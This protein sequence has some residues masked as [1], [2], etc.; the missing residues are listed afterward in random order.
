MKRV[1]LLSS[2]LLIY[3]TSYAQYYSGE[4]GF[5]YLNIPISPSSQSFSTAGAAALERD[6]DMIN[7]ASLLLCKDDK[8][9]INY[10]NYIAGSHF[11]LFTYN[12]GGS[13]IFLKYFNSGLIERRD[14]LNTDLGTYSANAVMA[15]YSK[16]FRISDKMTL[17][18]GINL[19]FENITDYKGLAASFDLGFIFRNIYSDFL[20]AGVNVT[21]LGALYDFTETSLSPAKVVAGVSIS[22]ED[23][24]FAVYI[25]AGKILDRKYF[26]AAGME[27]FLV[28]AR[29]NYSA[30]IT[31]DISLPIE[32]ESLK[33]TSETTFNNEINVPNKDSLVT[34]TLN[35]NEAFEFEA[36]ETDSL[37]VVQDE[38]ESIAEADTADEYQSYADYLEDAKADSATVE[39]NAKEMVANADSN[40][41]DN[42]EDKETVKT[43]T[44]RKKSFMDPFAFSFRWGFSSDREDLTVGYGSDLL[45]G[46]SAGFRMSYEN[47]SVSYSAKMWGQ[48]GVT[49]SLGIGFSF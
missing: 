38:S 43:I 16:A 30:D 28:R 17:G 33:D 40:I 34:D 4:M 9:S 6:G 13:Q 18:A 25:D 1:I 37:S 22:K 42:Q 26:Y 48:L 7:P 8:A 3:L 27:F 45:A 15:N 23:M 31:L 29:E 5:N 49:Q 21:N 2:L 11:G 12:L 20:S 32:N 46:F 14:S 39:E 41:I 47:V 24:P 10:M 19:G 36:P 35:V 44:A